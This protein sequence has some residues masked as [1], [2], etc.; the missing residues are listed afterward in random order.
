MPAVRFVES[1]YD[2]G[3]AT[4]VLAAELVVF[5]ALD[6][7]Q[8]DVGCTA[9]VERQGRPNRSGIYAIQKVAYCAMTLAR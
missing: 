6:G 2:R 5:A 3:W 4:G 9:E 7:L 8:E 1:E